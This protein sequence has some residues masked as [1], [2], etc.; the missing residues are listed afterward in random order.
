VRVSTMAARSLCI[1]PA[2][3]TLGCAASGSRE[4]FATPAVAVTPE[5][6]SLRY[7]DR[8]GSASVRLFP[9]WVML[10]GGSDSGS[11]VGR[12]HPELSDRDWT[13]SMNH[14]GWKRISS[15]SLEIMFTGSYEGIRLRALRTGTRL[16]GRATWLT[17]VIGLTESSMAFA[18]DREECPPGAGKRL[19]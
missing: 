11:A 2:A 18:G 10:L 7:S 12:H 15:D 19:P 14:S 9:V 4:S 8:V 6:Y 3:L 16:S 17:D 13:E 5:C 1:L